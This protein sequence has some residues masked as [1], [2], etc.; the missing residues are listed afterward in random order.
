MRPR[1]FIDEPSGTPSGAP[2]Q[3][4][5]GHVVAL[6]PADAHHA[7]TVLRARTGDLVELVFPASRVEAEGVVEAVDSEVTVRVTKVEAG[8]M[9]ARLEILLAQALCQPRKIDEIIEKGTEVGVDSFLI[10]P[11]TGSPDVP[12]ERIEARLERWR[13]IAR[14]AAKQSKQ[15]AVPPVR[16]VGDLQSAVCLLETERW[17]SVVLDTGAGEHLS[18]VLADGVVVPPWGGEPHESPAR[19]A[20]W[21]GP[22]GGWT[23]DEVDALAG[24]GA[25]SAHLGRRVF[26]TETAGPVAGALTRGFLSDW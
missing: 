8:S 16:V 18:A 9:P 26:R 3:A 14:E 22:E 25:R 7:R 20:L 1:F 10:L 17:A 19:V 5:P 15:R 24:A 4:S 12:V 2:S 13:A 21:V 6:T 23:G 11:A